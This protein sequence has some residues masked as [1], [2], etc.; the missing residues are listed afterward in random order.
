MK[1][2]GQGADPVPPATAMQPFPAAFRTQGIR[3]KGAPACSNRRRGASCPAHGYGETGD[4]WAPLA[5][6]LARDHT[7]I[8][9]DLRGMGLP[10]APRAATTRRPRATIL[11][12]C[13]THCRSTGSI[14][15]S[16][17]TGVLAFRA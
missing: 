10:R 12:A 5:A 15:S 6:E 14:G 2:S 17:F 3:V 4:M 16:A 1:I 13:S 11:Q 8:A 7:V 9:P